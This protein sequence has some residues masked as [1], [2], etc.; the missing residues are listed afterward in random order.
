MA[1][2]VSAVGE[3]G[4]IIANGCDGPGMCWLGAWLDARMV[5]VAGIETMVDAAVLHSLAVVETMRGRGI[6]AA[7]VG[8]ARKAAH[9]RGARRLYAVAG[10][11]AV[12][13]LLRFGFERTASSDMLDEL[14]GTA[15]AA[16]FDA[17]P[18]ALARLAVLH[19][20]ISRDGVIER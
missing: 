10:H 16:Y 20:D 17:C 5:G 9:T 15:V 11:N 8:A 12:S 1:A 13:Y 7:L 3:R 4:E 6:G 14:A 2:L 19:L 18:Q